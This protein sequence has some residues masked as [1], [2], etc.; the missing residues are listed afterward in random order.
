MEKNEAS[1]VSK[2]NNKYKRSEMQ[3]SLHGNSPA[4]DDMLEYIFVGI[5][6]VICCSAWFIGWRMERNLSDTEMEKEILENNIL[7]NNITN[8]DKLN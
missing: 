4:Q 6:C 3:G 7:E 5:L 8:K 1:A 2:L